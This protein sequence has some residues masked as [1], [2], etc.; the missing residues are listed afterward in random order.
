MQRLGLISDV[1][2]GYT[3]SL[4]RG[5][6]ANG[7]KPIPKVLLNFL[8][9]PS[10]IGDEETWELVVF[11]TAYTEFDAT[12]KAIVAEKAEKSW[13]VKGASPEA[14]VTVMLKKL[15]DFFGAEAN[16]KDCE[17]VMA[18]G[19]YNILTQYDQL[20][21]GTVMPAVNLEDLWPR[22]DPPSMGTDN[23]PGEVAAF[24]E[25]MAE[26]TQ[27]TEPLTGR[28][29][30]LDVWPP[31]KSKDELEQESKGG[32]V[33]VLL[34]EK[35]K[36]EALQNGKP[37][38]LAEIAGM[39]DKPNGATIPLP[40][41]AVVAEL[42]QRVAQLEGTSNAKPTS[43]L[44]GPVPPPPPPKTAVEAEVEALS[45]LWPVPDPERHEPSKASIRTLV[46][47]VA[48]MPH[49]LSDIGHG[50]VGVPQPPPPKPEKTTDGGLL[51]VEI[52]QLM[53]RLAVLEAQKD[54]PQTIKARGTKTPRDPKLFSKTNKKSAHAARAR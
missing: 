22:H 49:E 38:S 23:V 24:R 19:M 2:V 1:L 8:N 26:G 44:R 41:T 39:P 51:S 37:M 50:V 34:A 54:K 28:A 17:H 4:N 30:G 27:Q 43:P 3:N 45:D 29:A 25:K 6:F 53:D 35:A 12:G 33:G 7:S 10:D 40:M 5:N 46:R 36:Q 21:P 31:V 13:E 9:T 15:K 16:A 48:K 42:R 11:L 20:K 32:R 18:Q 52:K 47:A 14:C